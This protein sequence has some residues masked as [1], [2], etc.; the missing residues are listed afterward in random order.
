MRTDATRWLCALGTLALAGCTT[1]RPDGDFDAVRSEVAR[2]NGQQPRWYHT[3]PED[4]HVAE[5]TRALLATPLT[6]DTAVELALLNN[7]RLQASYEALGVARADLVQA[8]LLVN[9]VLQAD[10][11]LGV[12]APGQGVAIGLMQNFMRALQIP[13][14]KRIAEA[15]LE[16]AKFTVAAQVIELVI[17]VKRAFVMAQGDAQLVELDR[18]VAEA[19]RLAAEVARKQRDAGNIT[20]LDLANEMALFEEARTKLAVDEAEAMVAHEELTAF[21]GLWGPNAAWT[22]GDRLPDPA[23]HVPA[24]GLESIAVAQRLD[25][26]AARQ[27]TEALQQRLGLTGIYGVFSDAELG[28]EG[29]RDIDGGIWSIGPLLSLPIPIFDQGQATRAAGLA[30]L[31]QSEERFAALAIEIRSQVRRARTRLYAARVLAEHYRGVVLPLRQRIVQQSQLQYNGMQVGVFQLLQARQAQ[32]DAGRSY[33]EAIK[34][35][36]LARAELEGAVGGG[37]PIAPT[38]TALT[39]PEDHVKQGDKP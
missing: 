37:L 31:R 38:T 34:S 10:I 7:R 26:A 36:W 17:E 19:T 14:R 15:A 13:L 12:S 29:E 6:E 32:I 24:E 25:L 9:P 33:V 28:I 11:T 16:E 3:Q 8:G 4:Q 2:R 39:A 21:M 27:A 35:Y 20:D 22:I 5:R 30:Q 18:T 1:I 23:D